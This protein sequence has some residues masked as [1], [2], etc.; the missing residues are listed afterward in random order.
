MGKKKLRPD[1]NPLYTEGGE[2]FTKEGKNYKGFYRIVG[3]KI[4]SGVKKYRKSI[5]LFEKQTSYGN[6]KL[7]GSPEKDI[8]ELEINETVV[9]KGK[10]GENLYSLNINKEAYNKEQLTSL[11]DIEFKEFLSTNKFD[12][13]QFFNIYN[14]LYYNIPI[15]GSNSHTTLVE[16]SNDMLENGY[17]EDERN[18]LLEKIKELEEKIDELEGADDEHPIFL[19]GSFVAAINEPTI[20]YMDSGKARPLQ[21]MNIFRTLVRAR[22]PIQRGLSDK[23]FSGAD[24]VLRMTPGELGNIPKGR[25]YGFN[26]LS[27]KNKPPREFP[28]HNITEENPPTDNEMISFT[29][30]L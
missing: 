17:F 6:S 22:D 19:N 20:F 12:I 8:D 13:N 7:E 15:E 18:E 4:M 9:L 23:D 10:Q 2:L 26:D 5:E 14:E 28:R 24:H 3:G 11:I 16:R 25:S 30:P 29:P 27:G 21:N 1:F